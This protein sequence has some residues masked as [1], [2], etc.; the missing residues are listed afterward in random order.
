MKVIYKKPLLP[1]EIRD[2]GTDYSD[3][4][5]LMDNVSL[6]IA[7]KAQHLWDSHDL[8]IYCDDDGLIKKLDLNF[9]RPT[10]HAPIVGNV[11]A[12]KIVAAV[13][14]EII[15]TSMTDVEAES[16]R[17]MLNTWSKYSNALDLEL[18]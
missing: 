2:I 14:D 12:V 18:S 8:I 1:A 9:Y 15:N 7:I 10:D 17:I 16:V 6:A 4:K 13:T 3:I 5:N 11:V